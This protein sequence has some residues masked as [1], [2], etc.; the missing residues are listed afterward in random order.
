MNWHQRVRTG[1]P[2][3]PRVDDLVAAIAVQ[4]G[5]IRVRISLSRVVSAPA[6][7][8]KKKFRQIAHFLIENF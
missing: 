2:L 5:A 4:L 8:F 1:A 3:K 6:R 7:P